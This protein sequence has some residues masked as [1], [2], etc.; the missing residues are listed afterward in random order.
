MNTLYES[1]SDYVHESDSFESSEWN[2]NKET[3]GNTCSDIANRLETTNNL[4]Q[5]K[6]K[7]PL[8]RCVYCGISQ[9]KL[10]RRLKLK[11]K[12]LKEVKNAMNAT[13]RESF[14]LFDG[15]KK[16]GILQENKNEIKENNP[17]Y[18]LD[19]LTA[20][21]N[22]HRISTIYA[23]LDIPRNDGRFFYDHMGHSEQINKDIYQAP[24]ALMEVI[25]VGKSLK[26]IDDG[27]YYIYFFKACCRH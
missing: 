23:S 22:R 12:H 16:L 17:V 6:M 21:K 5:P 10:T 20:T 15:I 25:K 26:Q 7:K 8:R 18:I 9:T 14:R 3:G 2:T 13:K 24:L 4:S 27:K 19:L 1:D 11:H